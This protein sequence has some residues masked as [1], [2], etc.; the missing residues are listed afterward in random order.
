MDAQFED[1]YKM[2]LGTFTKK[3]W[4][5]RNWNDYMSLDLDIVGIH[6]AK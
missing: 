5:F 2:K 4:G 1:L 6:Q 3:I